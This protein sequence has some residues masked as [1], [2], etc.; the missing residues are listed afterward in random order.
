MLA[1][2]RINLALLNTRE[3]GTKDRQRTPI[4]P[5]YRPRSVEIDDLQIQRELVDMGTG[6]D[7]D[8]SMGGRPHPSREEHEAG[9]V[10][11]GATTPS[12]GE[13]GVRGVGQS[14]GLERQGTVH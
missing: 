1:H 6:P 12:S 7:A 5:S 14:V 10:L 8:L 4:G 2:G 13:T 3:A 11:L 9:K